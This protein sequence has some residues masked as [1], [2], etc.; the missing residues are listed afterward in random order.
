MDN[1][2]SYHRNSEG[3]S[4]TISKPPIYHY[5]DY[6]FKHLLIHTMENT[7]DETTADVTKLQLS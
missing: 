2:N 4:S 7:K 3:S 1:A 5:Y 6:R